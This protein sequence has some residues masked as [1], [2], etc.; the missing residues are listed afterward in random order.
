MLK[1]IFYALRYAGVCKLLVSLVLCMQSFGLQ[2]K[3]VYAIVANDNRTGFTHAA[4]KSAVQQF[5][6][7]GHS[8]DTLDLYDHKK[9]VPF[10][11]HSRDYLESFPLYLDNKAR[12]LKADVLLLVFPIYWYDVPAI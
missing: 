12:F 5:E 2:A 9:E 7:D 3:H 10:F 8:V 1:N 4:C 6:K 11:E